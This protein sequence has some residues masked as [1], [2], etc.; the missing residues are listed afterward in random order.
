M[1][2]KTSSGLGGSIQTQTE[3]ANISQMACEHG[4]ENRQAKRGHTWMDKLLQD[5]EH[6]TGAHKNRQALEESD[7]NRHMEAVEDKGEAILGF[8][9]A[10]SPRVDGKT[11]RGI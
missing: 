2:G 8:A 11:I 1:E 5:G 6:E 10:R 7:E 9:K 4:R 3:E